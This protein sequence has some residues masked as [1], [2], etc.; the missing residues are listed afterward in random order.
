MQ[1]HTHTRT[2]CAHLG[3]VLPAGLSA[4][5]LLPHHLHTNTVCW[6]LGTNTRHSTF[7]YWALIIVG[8]EVAGEPMKRG[9]ERKPE[10]EGGSEQDR[11]RE[12]VEGWQ[13][14]LFSPPENP[15]RAHARSIEDISQTSTG[16]LKYRHC[17]CSPPSH[18]F[19]F[20]LPLRFLHHPLPPQVQCS[21]TSFISPP[22]LFYNWKKVSQ[23]MYC[24]K[25]H[26]WFTASATGITQVRSTQGFCLVALQ[27][28]A[29][30]W[31]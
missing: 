23:K 16:S 11:G 19:P 22:H 26:H 4:F 21:S 2:Q 13:A 8:W 29:C 24:A 9:R 12:R 20:C 30:L 25:A 14:V 15:F 3:P 5:S 18:P 28:A 1:A 31:W 6:G 7:H 27:G 10:R 17:R